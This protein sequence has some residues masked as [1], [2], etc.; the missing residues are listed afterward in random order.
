MTHFDTEKPLN[1]LDSESL[2]K[3]DSTSQVH[4]CKSAIAVESEPCLESHTGDDDKP[5]TVT[6]QQAD[7]LSHTE[8]WQSWYK[9][10]FS[11]GGIWPYLVLFFFAMLQVTMNLRH[12]PLVSWQFCSQLVLCSDRNQSGSQSVLTW[13][14][15]SPAKVTHVT[16][17]SRFLWLLGQRLCFLAGCQLRATQLQGLRVVL[18]WY[19]RLQASSDAQTPL[20]SASP[21]ARGNAA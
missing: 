18:R 16:D 3:L 9:G 15:G 5:S 1:S 10:G 4:S 13:G 14:L 12:Y 8:K 17:W 11:L 19:L 6:G 7:R 20:I 2:T 21:A